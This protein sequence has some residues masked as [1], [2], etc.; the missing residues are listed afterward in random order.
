MEHRVHLSWDQVT[1]V[2][3]FKRDCF[4]VD[5]IRLIVSNE[6]LRVW[7]E[8]TEDEIGYE[9]MISQ[10]PRHLMGFPSADDWWRPVALPPFKTNWTP[11]YR[12]DPPAD[13]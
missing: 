12:R 6:S 11:L 13:P 3:A 10:L 9:E 2:Y 8:M 7:I 1:A 5:Q 4:S